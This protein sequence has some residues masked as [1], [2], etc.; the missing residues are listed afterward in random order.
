MVTD[1]PAAAGAQERAERR[2]ERR[3]GVLGFTTAH[4][5]TLPAQ[6]CLALQAESTCAAQKASEYDTCQ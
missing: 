6:D 5:S 4:V 1:A 3:A 2:V